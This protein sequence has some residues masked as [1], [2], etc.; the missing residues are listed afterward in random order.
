MAGLLALGLSA[1]FLFPVLFETKLVQIDTMFENYYHYSVH[2][3]SL[4]QLFLSQ[5]WGDGPSIW[6]DPDAMSYSI[7]ILHYLIPFFIL[8]YSLYRFIKKPSFKVFLP[9]LIVFLALFSIVMTHERFSFLWV[10]LSPI[11]KIQFPWRFLNHTLFLFSLSLTFLPAII[12]QIRPKL[13]YFITPA[14]A[15]ILFLLNYKNFFPVS[16]GPLTDEIKFSEKL[17]LIKLLPVFMIICPKLLPPLPNPLP[18]ILSTKSLLLTLNM[19]YWLAK[20]D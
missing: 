10:I 9:I 4:R 12:N 2:F 16:Y 20:G 17:G 1:F 8:I 5:F 18:K 14:L 19:N 11:Q 6:N 7:G 13:I 15:L 3:L